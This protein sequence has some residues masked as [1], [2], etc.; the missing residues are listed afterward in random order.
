MDLRSISTQVWVMKFDT[1]FQLNPIPEEEAIEFV[2]LHPEGV[3]HKWRHQSM[4]TLGHN[5]VNTYV[6]F[7]ERLID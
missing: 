6:V 5:Q 2:A 4:L 1:Y 7:T 3:A